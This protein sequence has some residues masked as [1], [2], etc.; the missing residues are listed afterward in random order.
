MTD[1]NVL[2][3]YN[4]YKKLNYSNEWIIL[5]FYK[6]YRIIVDK[7]KFK[8]TE[9]RLDQ[10]SFRNEIIKRDK[11]CIISGYHFIECEAA[12]IIPFNECKNY[13]R[14]NGILLNRCLHKLFDDYYFSI[15]P[16]TNKVVVLTNVPD[17]S[18]EKFNN[19]EV[20]LDPECYNNLLVHY[21]RFLEKN[22]F[23]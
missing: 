18:I 22:K 20:K 13:L 16:G 5:F 23:Q 21:G 1:I 19:T 14:S 12:H 9:E 17:V 10:D 8:L 11:R 4:C 2:E 6:K 15:N 3:I 7:T